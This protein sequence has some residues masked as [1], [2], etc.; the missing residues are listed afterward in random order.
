MAPIVMAVAAVAGVGLQIYGGIQQAKAERRQ[1]RLTEKQNRLR[2]RRERL[3]ALNDARRKRAAFLSQLG[4]SGAGFGSSISTGAGQV[5]STATQS[6]VST[7]QQTELGQQQL[8]AQNSA[9]NAGMI[10]SLGG[11][12]IS[13]SNSVSNIAGSGASYKSLFN[14]SP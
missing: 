14:L 4:S 6:I 10:S 13:A 2:S 9:S 7:N 1:N 11:G 8:A 12:I 3:I 5:G